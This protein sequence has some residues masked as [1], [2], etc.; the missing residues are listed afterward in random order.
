MTQLQ[1][2]HEKDLTNLKV[3]IMQA[4]AFSF[5]FFLFLPL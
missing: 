4:F 1:H 3:A 5:F 2:T